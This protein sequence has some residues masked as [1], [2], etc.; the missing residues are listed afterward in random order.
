MK[1]AEWT[2]P[3]WRYSA[4]PHSYWELVSKALVNTRYS[5]KSVDWR[6]NQV[7]VQMQ[8][9]NGLLAAY[10]SDHLVGVEDRR[11]EVSTCI[12]MLWLLMGT[13]AELMK[14]DLSTEI[15]KMIEEMSDI[16]PDLK[17]ELEN[18]TAG[19]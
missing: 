13:I 19:S 11:H 8:E 14:I 2:E 16:F 1:H 9:F 12:S 18:G 4:N 3:Q 6:I 7:L 15:E 5:N 17:V 10:W